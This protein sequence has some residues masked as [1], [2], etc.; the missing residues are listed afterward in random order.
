MNN[1]QIHEN[2]IYLQY[3]IK[4]KFLNT[5]KSVDKLVMLHDILNLYG[6]TMILILLQNLFKYC[7]SL[8]Q[9]LRLFSKSTYKIEQFSIKQRGCPSGMKFNRNGMILS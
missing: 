4:L 1:K 8:L 3:K 7:F 9:F 2:M 6:Y 5:L